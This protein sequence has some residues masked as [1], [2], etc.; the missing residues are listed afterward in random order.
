[1]DHLHWVAIEG[2]FEW[3]R[4]WQCSSRRPKPANLVWSPREDRALILS[5][6]SSYL[7]LDSRN[8]AQEVLGANQAIRSAY[9]TKTILIPGLPC[10]SEFVTWQVGINW[11]D[12]QACGFREPLTLR[13]C[14]MRSLGVKGSWLCDDSRTLVTQACVISMSVCLFNVVPLCPGSSLPRDIIPDQNSELLL[15]KPLDI[16]RF[17]GKI[18]LQ[19]KK[20]FYLWIKSSLCF[21]ILLRE[22]WGFLF[23]QACGS[24]RIC[25]S[26]LDFEYITPWPATFF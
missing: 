5:L 19:K 4:P 9:K 2:C 15:S 10:S 7:G 25:N 26:C 23:T 11:P 24:W 13:A 21:L 20:V 17:G 14:V 22:Q 8:R 1:M 6:H 16:F 12:V 18:Y 3:S